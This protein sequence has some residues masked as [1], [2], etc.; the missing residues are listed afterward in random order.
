MWAFPISEEF[1]KPVRTPTVLE[2]FINREPT[3]YIN[4]DFESK[5]ASI[6]NI[7]KNIINYTKILC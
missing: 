7:L 4:L 5:I 3:S 1:V 6:T 2:D